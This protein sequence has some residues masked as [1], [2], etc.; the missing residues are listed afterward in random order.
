MHL[1][2]RSPERGIA[3]EIVG[4]VTTEREFAEE[5]RVER[6]GI[7]TIPHPIAAF[8]ERRGTSMYQDFAGREA[9][10]RETLALVE[11]FLADILLLDGYLYLVTRPML[12]R[13][14]NRILNLHFSDL[15]LRTPAGCPRFPGL[16][17]VRDAIDAGRRETRA[18]V[19]LVNEI[20]D[21]GTPIVR[22]WP[23]PVSPLVE[24]LRTQRALDVVE[25][26]VF[27][28]EQ[29]MMRTVSGPL[30]ASA[31]H[32][33]SRGLVDLDAIGSASHK[34]HE[35]WILGGDGQLQEPG[36]EAA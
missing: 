23:F 25:A 14:R 21:G 15:A 35:P 22:S 13:F 28:H 6:R 17:A 18:T 8:Y 26:Y 30:I 7:P 12:D 16:R 27:A 19:H 29:W 1:L 4:C 34:C 5:V 24:D 33:I 3:F 10:D 9:Y 20:P 11:P 36:V 32:L 2:N 31:L